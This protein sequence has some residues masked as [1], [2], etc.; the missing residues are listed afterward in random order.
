MKYKG[1][2]QDTIPKIP[3][4]CIELIKLIEEKL[5]LDITTKTRKIQYIYARKIYYKI[6]T[7]E[8]DMTIAAISKTLLQNH[9]TVLHALKNFTHDY[10]HNSSFKKDFD[11][12]YKLYG[13]EQED[14]VTVET[15]QAKVFKQ[16]RIIVELRAD[17]DKMR[18]DYEDKIKDLKTA[19]NKAR[20]NNIR[21]R[22]Q[23][24]K[25]YY[26]SEV[27]EAF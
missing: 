14:E 26:A 19:L 27:V 23:Q 16:K 8:T 21:P 2:S 24:T 17:M 18:S 25:I 10:N 4:N 7:T 13:G 3:N 22:N 11:R 12:I 1:Y 9:A 6:L 20:S 5:G 15:L